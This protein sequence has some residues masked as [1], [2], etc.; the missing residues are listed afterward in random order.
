MI[1]KEEIL[2]LL[3][4]GITIE[5]IGEEIAADLNAANKEYQTAAAAERNKTKRKEELIEI[6]RSFIEWLD[7][8]FA[9]L[10]PE[11]ELTDSD[12]EILAD[13]LIASVEEVAKYGNMF[14]DM[15]TLMPKTSAI[16]TSSKKEKAANESLDWDALID[17]FING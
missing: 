13:S 4:K 5:E 8:Y 17:A 6:T 12:I 3:N 1:N 16:K 10:A 7:T 9:E 15:A 11:E 2:A 14:K